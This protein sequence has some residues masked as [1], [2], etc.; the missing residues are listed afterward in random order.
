MVFEKEKRVV[1]KH[2]AK[3]SISEIGSQ[4]A[5]VM[6]PF[7]ESTIDDVIEKLFTIETSKYNLLP[8]AEY[9]ALLD[10]VKM[11]QPKQEKPTPI[12]KQPEPPRPAPVA[13]PANNPNTMLQLGHLAK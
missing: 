6:F 8:E 12:V 4:L 5:K 11:T 3:K 9:E 7:T 2:K 13:L 1:R 10:L